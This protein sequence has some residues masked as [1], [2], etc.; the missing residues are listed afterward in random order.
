MAGKSFC[1]YLNVLGNSNDILVRLPMHRYCHIV[2]Y[3]LYY[4]QL[5]LSLFLCYKDL[6]NVGEEIYVDKY[7][8]YTTVVMSHYLIDVKK[9]AQFKG[10]IV[11]V[12]YTHLRAHET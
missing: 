5:L 6:I 4:T 9:S 2:E 10:T 3:T 7:L 1:A 11:P 8:A 12:S